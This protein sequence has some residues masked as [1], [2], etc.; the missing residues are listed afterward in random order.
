MLAR[1]LAVF[2]GGT[3][4]VAAAIALLV[5]APAAPTQNPPTDLKGFG[6]QQWQMQQY[7]NKSGHVPPRPAATTSPVYPQRSTLQMVI[8]PRRP[9]EAVNLAVMGPAKVTSPADVAS[10]MA[11][12]P[13]GADLWLQDVPMVTGVEKPVYEITFPTLQQGV[14]YNFTIRARWVEDGKWVTQTHTFPIKAGEIHCAQVVPN[15]DP[16]A[17]KKV[18]DGLAG[19]TATDRTAAETQ[20]FCAVQQ[21]IRLGSMG[22]PVK[23]AVGGK[24]VFLCCEG[25]RAAALK[26][27]AATIKAIESHGQK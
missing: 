22:K 1:I 9:D 21:T 8:L 19:L 11:H 12:L 20:K 15:N 13:P 23:V 2:T 18:A 14:T 3:P 4:V 16:A 26:D 24:D 17:D 5:V 10:V 7:L 6:L 27:P 25:C